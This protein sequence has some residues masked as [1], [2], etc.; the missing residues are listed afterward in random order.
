VATTV[1]DNT[2]L[3]TKVFYETDLDTGPF[4][5]VSSGA[6]TVYSINVLNG[7]GSGTIN[8]LKIYDT[9]EEI[10]TNSTEPDFVIRVGVFDALITFGSE[11]LTIVNGLTLR[12]VQGEAT[13]SV[14]DPGA[15]AICEITYS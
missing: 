1:I 12:M 11:G 9:A 15:N 5:N 7:V 8:Y 2:Y 13:S 6:C 4:L 10:T 3:S 14:D